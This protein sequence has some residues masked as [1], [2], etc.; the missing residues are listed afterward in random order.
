M[1]SKKKLAV[2]VVLLATVV[3]AAR[4]LGGDSPVPEEP[5]PE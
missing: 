1:R 3:L 4:K 5:G 2:G